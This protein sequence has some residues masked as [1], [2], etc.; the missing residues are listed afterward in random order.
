MGW[1]ECKPLS[2]Y[3][4]KMQ[5]LLT[6]C[7]EKMME[8]DLW[9]IW[10]TR[11]P[12]ATWRS[13]AISCTDK[14]KTEQP[15]FEPPGFRVFT[16]RLSRAVHPH[17]YVCAASPR[18]RSV[19]RQPARRRRIS[20]VLPHDR[21]SRSSA[22]ADAVRTPVRLT[23]VGSVCTHPRP[24]SEIARPAR[25]LSCSPNRA[26]TTRGCAVSRSR[27]AGGGCRDSRFSARQT[28]PSR[29]PLKL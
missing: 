16:L 12:D 6:Q 20:R 27:P 11:P 15:I 22:P 17:L 8:G 7:G 9:L 14:K 13:S 29:R 2:Q 19:R 18:P 26:C 25:R 24:R 23:P 1:G 28:A 3:I 21:C 5:I 4:L 10:P